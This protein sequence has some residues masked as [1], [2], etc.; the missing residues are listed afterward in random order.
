L[1]CLILLVVFNFSLSDS[2]GQTD[3]KL[4]GKVYCVV[5]HLGKGLGADCVFGATVELEKSPRDIFGPAGLRID[6][7]QF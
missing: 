3:L 5:L 7:F 1:K 2:N 4:P 6:T